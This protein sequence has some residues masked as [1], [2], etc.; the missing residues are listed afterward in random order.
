MKIYWFFRIFVLYFFKIFCKFFCKF[1][2]IFFFLIFLF[3]SYF[4]YFLHYFVFFVYLFVFLW[5]YIECFVFRPVRADPA[6]RYPVPL[7]RGD[8]SSVKSVQKCKKGAT[9]LGNG[10][11]LA[12]NFSFISVTKH[13]FCHIFLN[14]PNRCLR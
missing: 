14:C 6:Q 8:Y 9:T 2:V 12:S 13:R 10:W 7:N 3:V 4:L 1:F 5:K 11:L